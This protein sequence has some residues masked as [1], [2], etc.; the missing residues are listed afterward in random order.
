MRNKTD[1]GR[2]LR[3]GS[4]DSVGLG[5]QVVGDEVGRATQ[6]NFAHGPRRVVGQVGRHHA[7]PK[8]ALF[9]RNILYNTAKRYE[10]TEPNECDDANGKSSPPGGKTGPG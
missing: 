5:L 8:L 1:L 7:D 3:H 6:G 9:N 2:G 4:D 10:Q